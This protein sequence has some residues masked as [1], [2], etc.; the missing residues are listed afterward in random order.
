[1]VI[2]FLYCGES[3]DAF[4]KWLEIKRITSITAKIVI[5]VLGDTFATHG[6]LDAVFS[7]KETEFTEFHY[8]L[9]QNCKEQDTNISDKIFTRKMVRLAG[10]KICIS[11][12]CPKTLKKMKQFIHA[13]IFLDINCYLLP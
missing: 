6:L 3:V 4:S 5:S 13:H 1:M 9:L 10:R 2:Y 12:K 11:Q 8:F 7:D